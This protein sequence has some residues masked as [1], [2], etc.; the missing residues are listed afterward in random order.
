MI[1]G[2]KPYGDDVILWPH[3]VSNSFNV[4]GGEITFSNFD[5]FTNVTQAAPYHRL[6]F[7]QP[8]ATAYFQEIKGGGLP[9]LNVTDFS[10]PAG[11]N[12]SQSVLEPSAFTL[13]ALCGLGV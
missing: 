8:A 6:A 7:Y 1:R 12:F 10:V 9:D 2:A 5:A 11:G 13:T 4:T 3:Q